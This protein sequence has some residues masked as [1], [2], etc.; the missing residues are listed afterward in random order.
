MTADSAIAD[1]KAVSEIEPFAGTLPVYAGHAFMAGPLDE[2]TLVVKATENADRALLGSDYTVD[3]TDNL[4]TI[5][6]IDDLADA[7]S[8]YV[9]VN[10]TLEGHVKLKSG[11]GWISLDFVTKL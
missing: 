2:A 11:A 5:T 1:V 9:T 4:L 7:S 3:F 10:K 6:L 8:I